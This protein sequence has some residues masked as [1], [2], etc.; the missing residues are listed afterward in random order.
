M[1][2]AKRW[3]TVP[4]GF[5]ANQNMVRSETLHKNVPIV[6]RQGG[7]HS[8][9]FSSLAL[10]S[11]FECMEHKCVAQHIVA[12]KKNLIGNDA[13]TRWMGLHALLEQKEHV[14]EEM[15]FKVHDHARGSKS[16]KRHNLDV[17]ILT[18]HH[19][20]ALKVHSVSLVGAN[21]KQDHAV[22]VVDGMMFDS[23]TMNAMDLCRE[24]LDWC[25][26]CNGG[27]GKT[28]KTL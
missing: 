22:A 9:L 6:H 26:N 5:D 13:N 17:E 20:D 4:I 21:G 2:Q 25:C 7:E 8:C 16:Q 15:H 18:R 1:P 14:H 28:G 23:S 10:A 19:E 24:A 3:L 11:A 12:N 27:F